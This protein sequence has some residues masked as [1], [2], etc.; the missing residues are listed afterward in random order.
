M[1]N[2]SQP[3]LGISHRPDIPQGFIDDFLQEVRRDDLQVDVR[4]QGTA[5]FAGLEWLME[6]ALAVY[7]VRPYLN[8]MLSEL[9]KDH[10]KV[11]KRAALELY[12]KVSSLQITRMSTPGKVSGDPIYSLAFSVIVVTGEEINLKF[13]IQPEL[14]RDDAAIA[15]DSF[16]QFVGSMV[17]GTITPE[18]L[19]ELEKTRIVGKTLLVAYDFALGKIVPVDPLAKIEPN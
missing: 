16:F 9:G 14:P 11:L 10:Y 17:D 3:D 2:L 19:D 5:V 4:A 18:T 6:T 13:L 7:I 15:F 1:Q 8:S 12:G